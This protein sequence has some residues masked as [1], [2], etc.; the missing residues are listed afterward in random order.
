M[1]GLPSGAVTFLFS[2]IEGSTRLV[3]ALR[4]RYPQVLAEHRDLFRAAI[5]EHAGYEVDTQGDAF[6]VAFA[7]AK[8]A[9]L[10]ALQVQRALAA[11]LWPTGAAVRV[12]MGI[13]TGQAVPSGGAYT[14]LAVHRAARICSAA[15]GGQV[16]VS[17]ATQTLVEDEEEELGFTLL[18]LGE[19]R[20]KDL[21]R[22]VR[23]FQL[24]ASGLGARAGPVAGMQARALPRERV[25]VLPFQNIS[26]D[27]AD[28][29]FSDGITEEL[30]DKLAQTAGL[31]VIARTTMMQYKATRLRTSEIGR[32]L[33]AGTVVEGSVRKAGAKIR[34]TAQLIDAGTDEHLWSSS[35]DKELDDIFAIQSDIAGRVTESVAARLSA[36]GGPRLATQAAGAERDTDDMTA[37]TDFLHGRQLAH[38]RRSEE[39]IRQALQFFERALARDP[40]F[41]RALVGKADCLLWLDEEGIEPRAARAEAERVVRRA[42]ELNPRLAEAHSMLA[43]LHL[44]RDELAAAKA[45]AA[46][47]M[48]LNPSLSEPYRW[49]AQVSGGE[50]DPEEMVRLAEAGYQIDPLDLNLVALLGL[51][52]F[53]AGREGQALAHWERSLPLVPYRT[54]AQ[55]AEYHLG[56][57]ELGQAGE[58]I[59][60]MKELRP[61]DP[62]NFTFEGYLAALRDDEQAARQLLSKLDELTEHGN[63]TAFM[64]GFVHFALGEMDAFYARMSQ[65]LQSHDL[66]L[67]RLMYSPLFAAARGEPR[68][69]D[70]LEAQRALMES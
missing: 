24:A 10:C 53:Y 39:T 54:N 20:L 11:H 30:I 65:A 13:H 9:V 68:F 33:G 43:P 45:E 19:H 48:Q 29:Y 58:A 36:P 46:A 25:A 34:V 23:L 67:L 2:D 57:G 21:D 1:M 51:A 40:A 7:G 42:L 37:Y 44:A 15:S 31:K 6:F 52:Y 35:Y 61:D 17:Q 3:K 60:R 49:L 66:P 38:D 70:L 4:D 56:R 12:R 28:E 47:A 62:W 18:D 16:L 5:A 26:P 22:P 63:A 32:E 41:A 14:G 8:Q 64:A 59:Q 69:R 50:G 55:L 27:P